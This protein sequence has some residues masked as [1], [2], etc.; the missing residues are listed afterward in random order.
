MMSKDAILEKL[1]AD[2]DKILLACLDAADPAEAV[3][4]F[5]SL[6][7]DNRLVCPNFKFN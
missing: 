3:K 2:A 7:E 1:R 4:R 6:K 5:V